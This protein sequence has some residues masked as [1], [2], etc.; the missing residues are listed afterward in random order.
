MLLFAWLDADSF[1]RKLLVLGLIAGIGELL[2]DWWLVDTTGTLVYPNK[3]SM[4]IRS[5]FYM[6]FAWAVGKIEAKNKGRTD[7][8]FVE[9]S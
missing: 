6:P 9:E 4:L 8:Y 7:M 3:E 5:P 2:A 1:L